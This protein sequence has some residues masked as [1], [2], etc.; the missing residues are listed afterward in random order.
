MDKQNRFLYDK[1]EDQNQISTRDNYCV[2]LAKKDKGM[3]KKKIF[4]FFFMGVIFSAIIGLMIGVGIKIADSYVVPTADSQQAPKVN[5]NSVAKIAYTSE[6]QPVA[7][8]VEDVGSSVVA[9]TSRVN[10]NDWFN[11][12]RTAQG[13][14]SGV[15]FSVSDAGMY[16]VTNAHVVEGANELIVSF[17][18]NNK[19]RATIIGSDRDTDLAVIKIDS[20]D[21]N[22]DLLTKIQPVKFGDSDKLRVGELAIAI[23][24][25]MGY[26]NSVTSGV[27]SAVNRELQI[28]GKKLNLIQTDAAINPGNS[29]G[30]LVNSK[31]E[32][33]GINTIK[34]SDTKVEGIGFAIP[35]N[36]AEPIVKELLNDGFIKRPYLGV[37]CQDIDESLSE[38]LKVPVGAYI[39]GIAEN[40]A[41]DLAGLKPADIII[42]FDGQKITSIENLS[43][44][45]KTK[46]VG[47]KVHIVVVRGKDKLKRIELM[48]TL[49]TK[50][51]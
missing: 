45:I 4:I 40:S 20:K 2:S 43:K 3:N 5:N 41:A 7:D 10:V 42:E 15:V 39:K 31:G 35:I 26:E 22:S 46:E 11:G 24:N 19:A 28:D 6:T 27:I 34:I 36:E 8:I 37:I 47:D 14:G 33:I 32:V 49:G 13:E 48:G 21:I 16:I 51:N 38:I 25:P 17:D 44:I 9:I 50:P 18:D 30:A 1:N 23:G 12:Q 29:G